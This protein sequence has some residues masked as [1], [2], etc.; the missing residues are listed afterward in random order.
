MGVQHE[1]LK[2]YS[3]ALDLD[4]EGA[5]KWIGKGFSFDR[6]QEFVDIM[7]QYI[8]SIRV[9]PKEEMTTIDND[10]DHPLERTETYNSLEEDKPALVLEVEE[11]SKNASPIQPEAIHNPFSGTK[12]EAVI[13]RAPS[14]SESLGSSWMKKS[15]SAPNTQR[16]QESRVS[17]VSTKLNWEAARN[18][19]RPWTESAVIERNRR[20]PSAPFS[21]NHTKDYEAIRKR[22]RPKTAPAGPFRSQDLRGSL[23]KSARQVRTP[24][25]TATQLSRKKASVGDDDTGPRKGRPPLPR[26]SSTKQHGDNYNT[27]DRLDQKTNLNPTPSSSRLRSASPTFLS[28]QERCSPSPSYKQGGMKEVETKNISELQVRK[29][30]DR[31]KSI[32]PTKTSRSKS[33][34]SNTIRSRKSRGS[35]SERSISKDKFLPSQ[36]RHLPSLSEGKM[37]LPKMVELG[38][39]GQK[40]G[41][42]FSS[43]S[44]DKLNAIHENRKKVKEKSSWI[45]GKESRSDRSS[46][47]P[48]KSSET[49]RSSS[50]P[51]RS[52]SSLSQRIHTKSK[53][54]DQVRSRKSQDSQ[55]KQGNTEL[56]RSMKRDDSLRYQSPNNARESDIYAPIREPNS[57]TVLMVKPLDFMK[58]SSTVQDKID[59]FQFLTLNTSRSPR[60]QVD[61]QRDVEMRQVPQK[62]AWSVEDDAIELVS[63]SQKKDVDVRMAQKTLGSDQSSVGIK[64]H[65]TDKDGKGNKESKFAQKHRADWASMSASGGSTLDEDV[66]E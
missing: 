20:P 50:L 46:S 53:N 23:N 4:I 36:E 34:P 29:K 14:R 37:Y 32:S 9:K 45:E 51:P 44:T 61:G 12:K 42:G 17:I 30:S 27:A 60:L 31:G 40:K 65:Q 28:R 2:D 1:A 66:Q 7:D 25:P 62:Q 19:R 57:G 26:H 3:H 5:R 43:K 56:Q 58:E 47:A 63:N 21:R 13:S 8:K 33:V 55:Q 41:E 48:R 54:A 49:T 11:D 39:D 15:S 52:E 10:S 24:S 18:Y 38:S 16:T 64:F 35:L 6:F 59:G 22:L